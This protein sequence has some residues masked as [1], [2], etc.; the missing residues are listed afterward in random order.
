MLY[1]SFSAQPWSV[2]SGASLP[3]RKTFYITVW[4]LGCPWIIVIFKRFQPLNI[5]KRR[6]NVCLHKLCTHPVFPL[7]RN[8]RLMD[9]LEWEVGITRF[10]QP[11][12]GTNPQASKGLPACRSCS[13]P[14]L[15]GEWHLT[16]SLRCCSPRGI[17]GS[18]GCLERFIR[19]QIGVQ[20][21]RKNIPPLPIQ[22]FPTLP[23]NFLWSNGVQSSFLSCSLL[24]RGFLLFNVGVY[25]VQSALTVSHLVR[26][27]GT[28][29]KHMFPHSP[30][31][32]LPLYDQV[33]HIL[34]MDTGCW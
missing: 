6:G 25:V 32:D 30:W 3:C 33:A 4:V 20:H 16:F 31:W 5:A 11:H 28:M 21:V 17:P 29:M 26:H 34:R 24:Q 13:L 9:L 23:C 1:I 8:G 2:D 27:W 15:A 19:C 14:M 22:L 12:F 10:T 7:W 18:P